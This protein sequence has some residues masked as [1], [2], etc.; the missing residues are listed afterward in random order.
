MEKSQRVRQGR[1]T[2]ALGAIQ[3]ESKEGGK[4]ERAEVMSVMLNR[5]NGDNISD[6]DICSL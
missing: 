2:D 3:C 6:G 1:S 4:R 5:N